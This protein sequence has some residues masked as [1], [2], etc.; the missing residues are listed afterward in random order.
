MSTLGSWLALAALTLSAP[1]DDAPIRP[2]VAR[3]TAEVPAAETA[4]TR[5]W[6]FGGLRFESEPLVSGALV[7]AAGRDPSGRRALVALDLASGRMLARALLDS[8]VPLEAA[9]SGERVAVRVGA[10]LELLHLRGGRFLP[11]RSWDGAQDGQGGGFSAPRLEGEELLVR[12]GGELALY[13]LARREPRWRTQGLGAGGTPA[14]DGKTVFSLAYNAEGGA[15]LVALTRADGAQR[16]RIPLGRMDG[17]APSA[18]EPAELVVHGE[19]VFVRLPRPIPA[20]EGGSFPWARVPRTAEGLGQPVTLHALLSAPLEIEHGWIA[21]EPDPD[22]APRWLLV[23]VERGRERQLELA[24]AAHHTWLCRSLVP[25]SR[26][27]ELVHLAGAGVDLSSLELRWREEPTGLFRP[28]PVP[29]GTLV[30]TG[31]ELVCLR[32]APSAP[33]PAAVRA[34]A[35]AAAQDRAHGERLT[36]LGAK[37]LRSGDAEFA[38]HLLDEGEPLG[39]RAAAAR[40][41]LERLPAGLRAPS[42]PRRRSA[43]LAEERA[44]CERWTGAFAQAAQSTRGDARA[45]L[46]ELFRRV[47]DDERGRE[48]LRALLPGAARLEDGTPASWLEFLAVAERL[49]LDVRAPVAE[50]P[51]SA[52]D[53]RLVE[54]RAA[55]RVDALGYAS[56]RLFVVT[57]GAEPG[58]VARSLAA[59]EL[60]CTVLEETFPSLARAGRGSDPLELVLYPTREEYLAK[61]GSDLGGLESVLGWTAGHFD[62]GA[63][64]SRMFLPPDDRSHA[65]LVGVY[66]HELTHHWLSA[67][68][69]EPRSAPDA[70]GA[71]VVEGVATWAEEL[72]LDPERGTWSTDNPR[73]ASLDTLANVPPADLIPWPTFLR[74][75]LDDMRRLEMRPT[76][77]ATL[78][79]QLGRYAERSPMQLYY[80]QG[81]ALAHFL[82]QDERGHALF[83]EAV[84]AY[85]RGTPI[86]VARALGLAPE[87]LGRRV[88]AFAQGQVGP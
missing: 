9:L 79:W 32:A 27:G 8:P 46:F 83:L 69:G 76:T 67:H 50:G 12:E 80:S 40:A 39:G 3:G 21:P 55:W 63:N 77:R 56:P 81:G 47:P 85:Y 4:P 5:V 66:S 18:D 1:Q 60:L 43:L 31:D 75:S 73:A 41:E 58:A 42:D 71:W 23:Q 37:A 30:V 38:L 64:V 10:R 2:R 44:L 51:G 49:A 6:S 33:D 57:A 15:E 54:E 74:L 53:R 78:S 68:L 35:F 7:V 34:A 65:R 45:L 14:L 59:G 29:G 48:V 70:P 72:A 24:S 52:A 17:P 19:R 36:Q 88:R 26:S 62:A 86:D 13:D 82:A 11:E 28:V 87:E 22:G 16:A 20:V 25:A 61:S 84:Q